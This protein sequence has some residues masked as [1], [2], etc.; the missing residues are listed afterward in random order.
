MFASCLRV[1][2]DIRYI[3][4]IELKRYSYS[5]YYHNIHVYD[6][7][8]KYNFWQYTV[9]SSMTWSGHVDISVWLRDYSD[10]SRL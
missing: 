4:N 3:M 1:R 7:L 2:V 10:I 8:E 9:F 5:R 6:I